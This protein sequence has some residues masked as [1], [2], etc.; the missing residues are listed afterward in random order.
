V[1]LKLGAFEFCFFWLFV[2]PNFSHR[3]AGLR[4]E[5]QQATDDLHGLGY[6]FPARAAAIRTERIF[7]Y[8]YI[9]S[10]SI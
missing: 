5:I 7:H 4:L 1:I 8:Y 10:V 6:V 3:I 9:F 2:C